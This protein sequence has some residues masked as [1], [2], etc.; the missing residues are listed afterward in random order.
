[1]R[2]KGKISA[3]HFSVGWSEELELCSHAEIRIGK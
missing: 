2:K 3:A 1:M